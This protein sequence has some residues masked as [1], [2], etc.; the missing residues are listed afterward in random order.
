MEKVRMHFDFT[1]DAAEQLDALVVSCKLASRSE[2]I[3]QALRLL[4]F[5]HDQ[6]KLGAVL[7]VEQGGA[8]K[9]LDL[10]EVG[11]PPSS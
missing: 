7:L 9:E 1:K 5:V 10:S 2:T 3:K 11:I 4:Q 6:K 8:T